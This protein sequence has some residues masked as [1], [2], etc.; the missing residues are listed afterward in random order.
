MNEPRRAQS[1]ADD[2]AEAMAQARAADPSGSSVYHMLLDMEQAA[3]GV[4]RMQSALRA[5]ACLSRTERAT[6]DPQLPWLQRDDLANLIEHFADQLQGHAKQVE[7]Q[8][9]RLN[10]AARRSGQH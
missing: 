5:I 7:R 2:L 1:A 8:V 3:I 10:M 9:E 4:D 6:D